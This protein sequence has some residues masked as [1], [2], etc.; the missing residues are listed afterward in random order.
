MRYTEKVIKRIKEKD[1][2]QKEYIQAVEEVLNSTSLIF[3]KHQ[4]YEDMAILERLVEPERIISFKVSWVDDN[5]KTQVNRGYRVQYNGCLG[6][7]KGGLRFHPTVNEGVIKFLGF[8]QIF[9]NALTT[10]PIGGGKGGSDFDPKGKSDSEIRRFCQAFMLELYR[11]IGPDIDVPAGDMGV[12][13][14]EIGYLYGYYRRIKGESAKGVLTGKGLGYGGSLV[15][16][17]ATGFG[18]IYFFD[19]MMKHQNINYQNENCVI[20]GSGNVAIYAAIKAQEK[21]LKVIGMSDSKGYIIDEDIDINVIK[22]I[23][24]IRRTS[25]EEYVKIKGSGKYYPGSIYDYDHHAKYVFPCGTQNEINKEQALRMINNGL[26]AVNE[27]A[28]MPSSNEAISLYL[29]N[30]ILFGPGKAA[31]AGGVATSAL[32]MSQNSLRMSWSFEEV[33]LKLKDIMKAIFNQCVE[34][35]KE[36][37]L[38]KHNYV[39]GANLAGMQKV[40]DAMIAM[41][42]Y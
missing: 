33:D 21:G 4:E 27:G 8:E 12:G 38:E 18:L 22:E 7:Y 20:S 1:S 37:N 24:E 41:G 39:A 35:I 6:P 30:K 31:N 28:N 26:V 15:R 13:A 23:K 40:I 25:I 3:E 14:R 9:K 11:H 10:L 32:E 19:E 16:K 2:H 36:Y 34:Q 42:E 29:E 5:N 17:E